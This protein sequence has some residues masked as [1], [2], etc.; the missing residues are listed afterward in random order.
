LVSRR[1][2]RRCCQ[3]DPYMRVSRS[4]TGINPAKTRNLGLASASRYLISSFS[5]RL[6]A[7]SPANSAGWAVHKS[8]F[9]SVGLGGPCPTAHPWL[10]PPHPHSEFWYLV[11]DF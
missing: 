11:S 2:P 10:S 3:G 1:V 4:A 6:S 9:T 5:G 8:V 7:A